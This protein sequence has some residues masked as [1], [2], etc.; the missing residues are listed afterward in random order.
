MHRR[1]A[2]A[3]VVALA[4]T[5]AACGP[6]APTDLPDA[7]TPV[8]LPDGGHVTTDGGTIVGTVCPNAPIEPGPDG[9]CT[10]TAGDQNILLRANLL[11][12]DGELEN[13]ELLIGTDGRILCAA[14]SCRDKVEAAGATV[15][16]CAN[17]VASPGLI[18]THDHITFSGDAPPPPSPE[19]Y[20]QRN[21]WRK[22]KRGHT[23]I[24]ANSTPGAQSLGELR[25]IMG[26]TTSL[27]GSGGVDGLLRNLDGSANLQEGLNKKPVDFDTFPLGDSNGVQLATGCGYPAIAS[28]SDPK[29]AATDA[30]LPHVSEGID[31]EAHNE[32][33]CVT[34]TDNGGHDLA[35][36]KS[37]FIHGVGLLPQ[38]Y[39]LMARKGV[40]L[41]WSPRSNID[42]YGFTAQ[43]T[44]AS[45]AGVQIALGTDW[46]LS[47]SL[48]LLRELKCADGLNS[49]FYGHFFTDRQLWEMV[50]KNAAAVTATEDV[51]G[52][53]APGLFADVAVFNTQNRQSGYRAVLDADTADTLLVL[54]GGKAL[55]GEKA[56]VEALGATGCEDLDVCSHARKLCVEREI[57]KN[58][59][60]VKTTA[61]PG[62]YDLFFCGTPTNEPTCLPARSGAFTGQSRPDD[63]DGDGI[64]DA[65]DLC[66]TVFDP[67]RP[68]DGATQADADH[69]H[70]GDACDVCP[71][72]AN[73][74]TCPVHTTDDADFDGIADALDNC[75]HVA[76]PLQEDAD[77]DGTGDACDACPNAANPAPQP[78][79]F[80][81]YA[82]KQLAAS[83]RIHVADAI[84][85]ASGSAGYF[86]QHAP[87]D[88]L[89]DA[90]LGADDSAI[91]VSVAAGATNLPPVGARVDVVAQVETY[92]GRVQLS[93]ATATVKTTGNILPAAVPVAAS[94]VASGGPRAV[95]LESVLVRVGDLTVA[96][97]AP[98]PGAGDV[99]PTREFV[100]DAALRVDDLFFLTTPFP[101]VGE[102][103]AFVQG[104]LR[105]ANGNTKLEP[106]DANDLGRKTY[107]VG[108]DAP[109]TYLAL[110]AADAQPKMTVRLS[111]SVAADTVVALAASDARLTVPATVTILA[112]ASTAL[113]PLTATEVV[114]DPVQLT[115]RY[116]GL[117]RS[118]DVVVYDPAAPRLLVDLVASQA[119]LHPAET[120]TLTARLDAPAPAAGVHVPFTVDPAGVL[121]APA[122]Q[123]VFAE[124][125]VEASLEL[126]YAGP[127]L[128]TITATLGTAAKTVQVAGVAQQPARHPGP[129][130]LLLTEVLANPSGPEPTG[131]WFEFTNVAAQ[132]IDLDGLVLGDNGGSHTV[133]APGLTLLPGGYALFAYSDVVTTNGNLKPDYA[134]GKGS[135]LIQLSNGGDLV[136]LSYGGQ[137]VD[138]VAWTG[139]ASGKS[140]CLKAPY[141]D[142]GVSASFGVGTTKW[143]AAAPPPAPAPA[144]FGSPGAAN[145]AANCQ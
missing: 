131:E 72:D 116:D 140:M 47:G 26:G 127:G 130:D 114:A 137:E 52:A 46:T 56:V 21:D 105:L 20:E 24:P 31:V 44:V 113:V 143:T 9:Q 145:T 106:R 104:V 101:Q 36:S 3:V 92:F 16:A 123:L 15:I 71:L 42:L 120:A 7:G 50:T 128:A 82:L 102:R 66:P 8:V 64:P 142:N 5:A 103:I 65:Q 118:A 87:G 91:F 60:A 49:N 55:Y 58:L 35:L 34:S 129:G 84:V 39:L 100:V 107:L 30:Y 53:L 90:T 12:P 4:L 94:D 115:A 136:K 79:P 6:D 63:Q 25:Q 93:G 96:D 70:V 68:L 69:D 32:F 19:R 86:L 88:A 122:A 98:A 51:I 121:A 10:T 80:S 135:Y 108:F 62:A 117:A 40:G 73:A 126:T 48:N 59:A 13:G 75:P 125:D 1:V 37:A 119:T 23:K 77:H 29:I 97:I 109:R 78:C 89:Y 17:A 141:G 22:G 81:I 144:D 99:A 112:G 28:A 67:P 61:G 111:S 74:T 43:V 45:R 11:T 138:R 76:N 139:S 38:D 134:Y 18:N 41:I 54:R 132:P 124:G 27:V 133:V 14:C 110:G 2:R 57:G 33:L 83:A 95:K 85:T